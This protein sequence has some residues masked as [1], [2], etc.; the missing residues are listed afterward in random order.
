MNTIRL[1]TEKDFESISKLIKSENEL[2]F[3]Y[4]SG[5]FP[6]TVSQV[7]KLYKDRKDFTA[8]IE[9]DKIIGFAN[10]YDFLE[11]EFVFIGNVFIDTKQRDKGKGRK[12]VTHLISQA[13]DKYNLKEVR[14]SVFADNENAL[15]LYIDMGFELYAREL[16]KSPKGENI[17]LFH[18][19]IVFSHR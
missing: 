19:K 6:L 1:I 15:F 3:V 7:K 13:R 18:M 9:K 14:I 8:L 17:V 10:F 12:L 4:P 16:K 5:K 2:F 11:N